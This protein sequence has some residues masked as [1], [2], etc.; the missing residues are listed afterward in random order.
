MKRK[1]L[2]LLVAVSLIS[3][4]QV[5]AQASAC[6]TVNAGP[7]QN[8]CPG[9]CVNLNATIQGTLQTTSYAVSNIAYSPYSY[10]AGTQVLVNIDDTWTNAIN[11]PFCF[12]FFGNT[13]NQ[14]VI[15]SNGLIS[16]NMA[17][18]GGFCQWSFTAANAIPSAGVP[19]NSIMCP[20]HDIDPA[21]TGP[22]TATDVRYAVYG[23]APC[24]EMVINWYQIPMFSGSC[25]SLIATQQIVLHET[26]NIIDMYIQN[27]PLCASW[28]GGLAIEGIQNATG[29]VAYAVAGRNA[30]QWTATNDGKRFMPTGP[31]NYTLT[32]FGPSGSLGSANPINVCPSTTTTY[33]AQVVNSTCAGNITVSDQVTVFTTG[34]GIVTTGAQTNIQCNGQCT[35]SATVTVTAGT[36]P[37]TYNWSPAPGGGQGT[38]TATGLCAGVYTC[39]V[40]NAAGCTTSQ[41][42]TI[43]QVPAI[44]A[45]QTQ[46][47]VVCNGGCTGQASVVAGGGT[48]TYTYNWAPAPGG[49]QG[50]PTATGLC[51]GTYTCTITSGPAGCTITR[52][53]TITQPAAI[54]STM[55]MTPAACSASNGTATINVSGGTGPYSYNWTPGNPTGDG[56]PSVSNL[57][58]GAWICTVTDANGCTHTNTIN[59]TS[60]AGITGS[61]TVVQ[62]LCAGNNGSLTAVPTGGTGPY[63]YAWTPS[64]GSSAT[65]N[66]PAGSYSC[67][68]TDV[69]TGC[70]VQVTAV[71]VAPPALSTTGT[72]TN[73]ACN[74][75]CTGAASVNVTGGTGAYTYNWAPAPGGGQGTANA[76]ALCLG[77][78]TVTATDAQGCT[79]TRT[80]NITQP[81]ALTLA[82]TMT[83]ATCGSA[84]G[85]ACVVASG[86]TSPYTYSW[87]PSGGSASCATGL[88]SN[89]YTVTVTDANGCTATNSIN[90]TNS[91]AP[92]ATITAS[93]NVSCF[94]G[95]N[96]SATVAA[97]G[98][99]GPYT[100]TWTPV[101]GNAT[102]GTPLTAQNYT[103]TVSDANGCTVTATVAIT[104]PPVLTATAAGTNVLCNGAST[105]SVTITPTGGVGPYTY[106]WAPSGG[107]GNTAT[108]VP[109]AVYT[110]TVTDANN[111]TTTATFNVTQPTA[112]TATSTF[113]QAV[114]GSSNGQACVSPSG[115]AGGYTYSWAPVPGSAACLNNVPLGS[116]TCTITDANGCTL[117]VTVNVPSANTPT[118]SIIT[119]TNVT[120]FGG[121][122]GGATASSVGGTTPYTY[123]WTNSDPDSIL[124]AVGAG[125]YS[126]TVTDANGC[127]SS[128]GVTITEPPQLTSTISGTDV[129]CFG[130]NTGDATVTPSGGVGAY[131]YNWTPAPGG[132][133]GTATA[134]GLTAQNYSCT[135]TD[136]NGCTVQVNITISE[137]PL[138]T[139]VSAGFNVTCFGACDGQLV[140][141]PGGG[142][143]GYT[144]N[145]SS[146]C[147]SA[148]C[149]NAC[150]GIYTVTVTD[151][152]GCSASDTAL[153]TEPT[154]IVI[155]T[156]A[157]DA[158]CG[159]A[160][161]SASAN[162]SG[163][164]G[165]LTYQ[166]IAGP[167]NQNYNNIVANTYSVIVTDANGCADTATAVV[168]NINGVTA[169]LNTSVNLT[170]FQSADGSID[171]DPIGG[172][173]PYTYTWS[174]G[175]STTDVGTNLPAG[176]Y[177]ITVTDA[178]GCTA[179]VNVVL[180]EPPVLTVTASAT[181]ASVCSGT[182]VTLNSGASGGTPVYTYLWNP[183]AQNGATQN[184]TPA[185]TQ[186]YT[187]EVTD[188][189][190]CTASAPVLV[191]VNDVPVAALAGDV[192]AGCAPLCVNFTDNSTVASGAITG[193]SWDFG[194]LNSSTQQNPNHCYSTPGQYNVT[195]T[196]T[197]GAGCTQTITMNNYIDVYAVPVAA[198]SASPQPTTILSP[199][200]QF[201]DSSINAASWY[202]TF[203]DGTPPSTS[204]LQNPTYTYDQATCYNVVLEVT[205]VDGCVDSDSQLVCI[206]PDVIIYV[207]NAFTPDDDG[208]N[209]FFI[210][211]TQGID[212]TNYEMWIFDRWGNLIWYTDDLNE[213]WNGIVLGGSQLCQIDTYVWKIKCKDVLD[214]RHDLIGKVSLI[215]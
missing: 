91:G 84:N 121:T 13:Y 106:T 183:I 209:D 147:T 164:S 117:N 207:P 160:D 169:T 152:N 83:S 111:C 98:G 70:T 139:V 204:T 141:I 118:V 187:V 100:Y 47:N 205:S 21:V 65:A 138:L 31:P 108:N 114:C 27:K 150:A 76:T 37:F 177:T 81:P 128:I 156:S 200:I 173:A 202:W 68:I 18:A 41:S 101:G 10:S 50:T 151:L 120:C 2:A 113:T 99:T 181:P 52:T 186:T 195:I 82:M 191:T 90:V 75:Q 201:T 92:T 105:G 110:C 203:G 170:C 140:S 103:V 51:P 59:V 163:G 130:N 184:I 85:Q 206:N 124:N 142:A 119:T 12:Q 192:L 5:F 126:V 48:G 86:G 25:H 7:D 9:Q 55:N 35:G 87:A 180:T 39:T 125:S 29:T 144:F 165:V 148:A 199:T 17:Y 167:A 80:F 49:G 57:G 197:T 194:D 143:P 210:P 129:L 155:N 30:T 137:P 196:V 15:G 22:G 78:Y 132:G 58:P 159:Q 176:P 188:Q 14:F 133:Q 94:G 211:V 73:I 146:G 182:P 89:I 4:Q 185:A 32:W 40:S 64:G 198:F 45:T 134:T 190:G 61:V 60:T 56:T 67:V 212:A 157:V 23:T 63:T 69:S 26:T 145:W 54:T 93:T 131:T 168:N 20:Y 95:N 109:A 36:G 97:S 38:A 19:I 215:R 72:Q 28:N 77:V 122:D 46:T 79:I 107:P 43:T 178:A 171:I 42:F 1:I 104:Q 8:I 135:I 44:T 66:V 161:G 175:P 11:L 88:L 172:T 174:A 24:R 154:A 71:L 149:N 136:A 62:P 189:N 123:L 166:W 102:T 3:L 112:L 193:W 153:V 179:V 74:G 96:G 34:G 6:P 16:F 213:G 53:F 33:T 127:S 214:K 115:G 116:Y 162:A 158:N 208:N